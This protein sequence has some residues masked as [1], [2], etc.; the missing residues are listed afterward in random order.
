MSFHPTYHVVP[1]PIPSL[2][3]SHIYPISPICWDPLHALTN[4]KYAIRW[5]WHEAVVHITSMSMIPID[6]W[7]PNISEQ[8][9]PLYQIPLKAYNFKCALTPTA[10]LHSHWQTKWW[11]DSREHTPSLWCLLAYFSCIALSGGC[12]EREGTKSHSQTMC[13]VNIKLF[14]AKWENLASFNPSRVRVEKLQN[15]LHHPFQWAIDIYA[16]NNVLDESLWESDWSTLNVLVTT[17]PLFTM[18]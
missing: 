7:L 10:Y 14:A 18:K 9:I 12:G 5:T 3:H 13:K 15:I 4:G 1:S 17:M 2:L 16:V 6:F 11:H 8:L